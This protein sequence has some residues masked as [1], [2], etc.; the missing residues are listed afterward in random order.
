MKVSQ[1]YNVSALKTMMR[2]EER[3]YRES[4]DHRWMFP[5]MQKQEIIYAEK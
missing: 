2:A 4:L 3:C 1:F 5:E